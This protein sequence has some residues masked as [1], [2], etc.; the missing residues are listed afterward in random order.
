M[1]DSR[2]QFPPQQQ[3]YPGSAERMEPEPR[4]E[5]ADYQGRGLL[6]GRAALVT[7]GD[8]GIG[9]AVA[10]AFAKEG[11][12]VAIA[13]LEEHEDAR[14]TA[15]EL[16]HLD[17]LVNNLAYQ[18]PRRSSTAASRR[19]RPELRLLRLGAALRLLPRRGACPHRWRDAAGLTKR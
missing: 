16:G 11:A 10:V 17:I 2:Q 12:D 1:A 15:D 9:R 13:Y 3:E 18:E 14:R 8:S 19:H 4:D 7:G 5:M 6:D